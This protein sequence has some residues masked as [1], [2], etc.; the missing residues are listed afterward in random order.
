MKTLLELGVTG[1]YYAGG[2]GVTFSLTRDPRFAE[3]F[4]S[5][6]KALIQADNLACIL[7][8]RFRCVPY[9]QHEEVACVH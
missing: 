2:D 7:G 6:I 9:T 3:S 8:A 5:P 4:D 1:F